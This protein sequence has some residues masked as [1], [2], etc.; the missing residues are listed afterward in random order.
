MFYGRTPSFFDISGLLLLYRLL[1]LLRDKKG[2]VAAMQWPVL[3]D[4][5][6]VHAVARKE[7]EGTLHCRQRHSGLRVL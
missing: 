3:M 1:F 2:A 7:G 6:F 4:T 5:P